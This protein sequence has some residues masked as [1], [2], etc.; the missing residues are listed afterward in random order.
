MRSV[1]SASTRVDFPEPMSPV[2]KPL[3]PLAC[4]VQTR[5]SNVPQLKTSSRCRRKP[6][7]L[8]SLIVELGRWQSH[9][10]SIGSKSLVELIEPLGVHERFQDALHFVLIFLSPEDT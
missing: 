10:G 1:V 2:S 8:S 7:S 6:D 4:R 9:R 5:E 3:R